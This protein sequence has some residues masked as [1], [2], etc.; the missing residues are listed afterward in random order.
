MRGRAPIAV[1]CAALA[2]APSERAV[3]P[4]TI[5]AAVSL[6]DVAADAASAWSEAGGP[7]VRTTF[8]ASSTLARQLEAGAPFDVVLL[9][10]E[11]W[12]DRL[13]EV[14]AVDADSVV[15]IARG[16]LDV[17]VRAERPSDAPAPPAGRRWTTADPEHVPLGRYAAAALRTVGWWESAAPRLVPARDARAALGL[18]ERGEVDWGVVYRSDAAASSEVATV[19][20]IP[21]DAH[22]PVVYL[23]A[24]RSGAGEDARAVLASLRSERGRAIVRARGLD[25]PSPEE[26]R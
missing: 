21:S 2:C 18:V 1:A 8:A 25:A 11:R 9:A 15:P 20:A 3:V 16:A 14:R 26:P 19:L 6:A 22:P 4:V 13:V 24:V 23:G 17:V 10:D 12:M 5:A 7:R